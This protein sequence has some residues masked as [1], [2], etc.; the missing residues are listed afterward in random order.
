MCSDETRMLKHSLL[1]N[2]VAASER[3]V[4]LAKAAYFSL[5]V[6]SFETRAVLSM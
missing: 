3:L 6:L 5:T 4:V 1:L 2:K